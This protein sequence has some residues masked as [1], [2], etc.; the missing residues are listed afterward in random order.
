MFPQYRKIAVKYGSNVLYVE[1]TRDQPVHSYSFEIDYHGAKGRIRVSWENH[2]QD[3]SNNYKPIRDLL[4]IL[5]LL[6]GRNKRFSTTRKEY[7][8]STEIFFEL[9][10]N[11][12]FLDVGPRSIYRRFM[13]GFTGREIKTTPGF[14]GK[15][16]HIYCNKD[17]ETFKTALFRLLELHKSEN[18]Y[19]TTSYQDAITTK[20]NLYL[21]VGSFYKTE[22]ALETLLSNCHQLLMTMTTGVKS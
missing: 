20:H 14:I 9:P 4:W 17:R 1:G 3:F 6:K 11:E 15:G 19:L 5:D 22:Q 7:N 2:E 10:N 12:L 16:L 8:Y 13:Q 18:L 21:R